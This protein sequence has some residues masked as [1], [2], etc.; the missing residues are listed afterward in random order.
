MGALQGTFPRLKDRFV[1]E[2][3]GERKVILLTAVLLFNLQTRLVGIN[4]ILSTFMP[5]LSV[6]ANYFLS[7]DIGL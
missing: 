2:E 3:N 7:Q 5:H 6:E 1:C 4:E